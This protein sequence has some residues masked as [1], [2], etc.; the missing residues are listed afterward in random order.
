[1][2]ESVSDLRLDLVQDLKKIRQRVQ[3]I[4]TETALMQAGHRQEQAM[5]R[6]ELLPANWLSM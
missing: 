5:V 4:K 1:M 2:Q 6:A 3:A